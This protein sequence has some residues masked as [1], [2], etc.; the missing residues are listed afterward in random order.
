MLLN[1]NEKDSAATESPYLFVVPSE[2]DE[3]IAQGPCKVNEDVAEQLR[4]LSALGFT[5][6]PG[7]ENKKPLASFGE[8]TYKFKMP[9]PR[10]TER[11]GIKL[12][13]VLLVD[14]D[15]YKEGAASLA[16]VEELTQGLHKFQEREGG[17]SVHWLGLLPEDVRIKRD[18]KDTSYDL[19][20]SWNSTVLDKVDIKCGNQLTW[21]SSGKILYPVHVGDLPEVPPALLDK[22]LAY[23]A[24][25]RDS[26]PRPT[27]GVNEARNEPKA[28]PYIIG[29][30]DELPREWLFSRADLA[31][32]GKG[33]SEVWQGITK[34]II[35]AGYDLD[36]YFALREHNSYLAEK[37]DDWLVRTWNSAYAEVEQDKANMVALNLEMPRPKIQANTVAAIVDELNIGH[38]NVL[39]PPGLAGE[40]VTAMRERAHRNLDEIYSAAAISMIAAAARDVKPMPGVNSHSVIIMATA[41][42]GG[43]KGICQAFF[44]QACVAAL[45]RNPAG[46]PTSSKQPIEEMVENDGHAI[47]N[48]DEAHAMF[49]QMA[50]SKSA[51]MRDLEAIFL[52]FATNNSYN[53]GTRHKKEFLQA[54]SKELENNALTAQ[55]R[56]ILETRKEDIISGF[57]GKVKLVMLNISTPDNFNSVVSDKFLKSGFI[58]RSIIVTGPSEVRADNSDLFTNHKATMP[59]ELITK[60]MQLGSM[61]HQVTI[62][63]DAKELL[64]RFKTVCNRDEYLNHQKMGCLF[65]R[66]VERAMALSSIAASH[67]GVVT[68]EIAS[69]SIGMVLHHIDTCAGLLAMN[70]LKEARSQEEKAESGGDALLARIRDY[71]SGRKDV[72]HS[73]LVQKIEKAKTLKELIRQNPGTLEKALKQLEADGVLTIKT[74]DRGATKYSWCK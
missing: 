14:W 35:K 3:I 11:M 53:F 45:G 57:A 24:E 66:A 47:F 72:S 15:G 58:G 68:T 55:E 17:N 41:P 31:A 71:M 5:A 23:S 60:F 56:K 67:S 29:S 10:L 33:E 7:L 1:P 32:K 59:D 28:T 20:N 30:I 46:K 51:H 69:W 52:Q 9:I 39:A 21:L 18:D 44:N 2:T 74:G 36:F 19:L 22:L 54:V 34:D 8:S 73:T 26:A 63:D 70:E 4:L 40:I 12:G 13:R 49:D 43:G 42:T 6:V 38:V 65:V 27:K 50:D 64:T 61:N 25:K 62:E 37:R 16:E 48:V